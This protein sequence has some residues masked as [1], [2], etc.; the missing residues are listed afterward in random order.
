MYVYIMCVAYG[1][2]C[3]RPDRRYSVTYYGG[4]KE[5]KNYTIMIIII[6]IS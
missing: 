1:V 6:T 5:E 4:E 3:V 2:V